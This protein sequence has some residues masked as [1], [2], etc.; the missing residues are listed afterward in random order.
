MFARDA[1]AI[2]GQPLRQSALTADDLYEWE[3]IVVTCAPQPHTIAASLTINDVN[4]G[5]PTTTLG[6]P[7]WRWQWQPQHAIGRFGAVLTLSDDRGATHAERFAL[8][9]VPRKLDL[10][11]YESLIMA[12]QRDALAIVYALHGGREG[13]A[14]ERTSGQPRSLVE[15]YYTLVEGHVA[16]ALRIVKEIAARPQ[17]TLRPQSTDVRLAEAERIEAAAFAR[18]VHGPLDEV[19]DDL[20]PALQAALRPPAQTHG[21]P[22]PRTIAGQHSA[23]SHDT[24]EH[25]LLKHVLQL[26]VWRVGFVREIARRDLQRRQRNA[27][28]VASTAAE[29]TVQTW[30]ERCTAAARELRQALALPLFEDVGT[31]RTLNEPTHLMRREPRYRRLY[32]LYR[33]LRS[34]PFIAFDSPLLWLPIQD[35]PTL[36]EQWCVLQTIKALLP[37][38]VLEAQELIAPTEVEHGGVRAQRWTLHLRENAPLL[39]VHRADGVRFRLIYQRRYAPQPA[40][41]RTLGALDPFVRIPDI[42]IEVQRDGQPPTV[43]VI[44]AKY[45]VMPDGRVPQSALDDAYAYRSAIGIA[46][47]RAT[48]GAFLLFPGNIAVETADAVGALP[49]LPGDDAALAM[50]I[51]RTLTE[52]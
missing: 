46:G 13:A 51:N 9:I 45:R 26:L 21:G 5:A 37:L 42:A 32:A 43:L 38:G 6:D 50:L 18:I 2:N 33:A 8:R 22:L 27:E 48:L 20:L 4:L 35:L 12:V 39:A 11:R 1:I 28:I 30:I 19:A 41:S 52:P 31:I 24:I 40:T 16:A 25:R 15:E 36:Y 34:A 17:Q 23:G 29:T 49:L 10:E 47:S 7:T 3:P 44:D 14:L